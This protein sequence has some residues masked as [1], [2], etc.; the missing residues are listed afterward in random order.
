[1][2]IEEKPR[3]IDEIAA[4][5]HATGMFGTS[6]EVCALGVFDGVATLGSEGVPIGPL[7]TRYGSGEFCYD[8]WVI[9]R[10]RD[11]FNVTGPNMT[12]M[13]E[14]G[15]GKSTTVQ[16][17]LR[18][19]WEFERFIRVIDPRG[20]YR[21]LARDL[22]GQIIRL[23][24]GGNVTLNPLESP[25]TRHELL[26]SVA[27]ATMRRDLNERE[28]ALLNTALD[29]CGE[30]PIL[31]RVLDLLFRP[32]E[33]MADEVGTTTRRF[34]AEARDVAMALQP[35]CK[36]DLKGLFDGPTS[37]GMDF[38]NRFILLDLSVWW[39]S[40][41]LGILMTCA[42]SFLQA[43]IDRHYKT[44]DL[45]GKPPKSILVVD[46]AWKILTLPGVSAWLQE[47][48]KISR[49]E[50]QQNIAIL[51]GLRDFDSAGDEGTR[52]TKLAQGLVKD[53][54]T[55]VLFATGED[56]SRAIKQL[57]GLSEVEREVLVNG[58]DRGSAL[59]R[60]GEHR[61]VV[62]THATEDDLRVTS[63]DRAMAEE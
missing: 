17:Y 55:F 42:M 36:G 14:L 27:A 41:T 6:Q 35:L 3:R 45:L 7:L 34:A 1:M 19:Q 4:H 56:D 61:F 51:H 25:E 43:Q 9:Y 46:E 8:P 18:R 21:N 44:G 29:A 48:F 58:L 59:W 20:E 13:G 31:P 39:T 54:K 5:D 2:R 12:V 22:G 37:E 26:R 11:R 28:P 15:K 50:A 53:C 10:K 47:R 57:L 60:I 52:L 33:A 30:N 38:D 49:K 24:R 40:Q 63:P 62:S 32:T 16:V 23:E